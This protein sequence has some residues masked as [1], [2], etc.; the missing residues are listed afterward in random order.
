MQA[1]KG[2]LVLIAGMMLLVAVYVGGA[3]LGWF[4][5]LLSVVL[6]LAGLALT[7]GL[8]LKEVLEGLLSPPP[9]D[10]QEPKKKAP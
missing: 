4:S 5:F 1:L 7:I 9:P 2:F 8:I 6:L 10:D 3:L